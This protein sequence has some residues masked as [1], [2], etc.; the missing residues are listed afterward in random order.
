M[1]R[2]PN[3]ECLVPTVKQDIWGVSVMV[4][5]AILW[6]SVGPIITLHGRSTA[7]QYVDRLGNQ[8]Y[9]IIQTLF[10]KNAAAFEYSN[11][12]AHTAEAVQSA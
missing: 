5:A 8:A 7:K 12:L 2:T 4:W 9:L 1:C 6:C 3:P 11:A 10:F